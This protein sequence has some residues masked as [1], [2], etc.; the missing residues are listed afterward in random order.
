M[1]V[2][3]SVEYYLALGTALRRAV[4]QAD[5][6]PDL[7]LALRRDQ[8]HLQ[9][10]VLRAAGFSQPANA[11]G[12]HIAGVEFAYQN[13][14]TFLPA[15]LD[16][17]GVNLNYTATDS[18]VTLFE[19]DDDLPFF[20]QSDHI[21]NVAA[22]FEKFGIAAQVSMSF[23]SPVARRGRRRRQRR[24]LR[25]LVSRL[26]HE[27]QR[28]DRRRAARAPRAV[29]TSPTSTGVAMRASLT[30]APPTSATRGA[31]TPGSTGGS[32]EAPARVARSA[33]V[34]SSA[35]RRDQA[36]QS[37]IGAPQAGD[38]ATSSSCR[39]TGSP[40]STW[41]TP[42]RS[43]EHPRPRRCG[44]AGRSS[45]TVFPSVT[46]PSHTTLTTGVTPDATES[47]RTT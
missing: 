13:Y 30:A 45:E 21:G 34:R 17:L 46:H 22:L 16:G 1:N 4:L 31:C 43:A 28:A 35:R 29:A 3:A 9:R 39:S 41:R 37:P 23:N 42:R 12:G 47:S 38:R 14:F 10:P 6:Q 19:R 20:K 18:S 44:H 33:S 36:A 15:P 8:R 7:R 26:G 25:R 11:D 24:C 27:G 2:D 32:G 40:H 5:R